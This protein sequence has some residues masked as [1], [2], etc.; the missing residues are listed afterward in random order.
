MLCESDARMALTE[1]VPT[2]Y[3][4]VDAQENCKVSLDGALVNSSARFV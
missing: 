1:P 3:L 2:A 4:N